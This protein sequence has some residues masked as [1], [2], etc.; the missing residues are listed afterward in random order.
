[1]NH[2]DSLESLLPKPRK[3]KKRSENSATVVLYQNAWK[4]AA[5]DQAG[6]CIPM[7]SVAEAT[8]LRFDLYN[9][10]RNARN[11]PGEYPELA[12]AI[13][14]CEVTV[15][16]TTVIIRRKE[17]TKRAQ[18]VLAALGPE[19][20]AVDLTKPTQESELDASARRLAESLGLPGT[21]SA[22]AREGPD[23]GFGWLGQA[24]NPEDVPVNPLARVRAV[25][26][27]YKLNPNE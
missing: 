6:K 27:L 14:V 18:A 17:L 22:P 10:V 26:Q 8:K 11:H 9:A 19:A 5:H 7:P 20:L 15:E 21:E 4:L 25:H 3:A 23:G 13:R 24:T 1:M 2:Q 12:E 16:G